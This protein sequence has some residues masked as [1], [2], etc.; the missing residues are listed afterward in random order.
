MLFR[1]LQTREQHIRREKATSNICTAQALLANMAG[2]YAVFHGPAG[3]TKT[4]RRVHATAA[5]LERELGKLGV[6]Q[7]NPV[8]FDTIRLAVPDA[9][10][11][12]AAALSVRQNF[13]YRD[14]GTVNI[15]VDET[16]NLNDVEAIV[17]T[18]AQAL[19]KSAHIDRGEAGLKVDYAA[20]LARTS[21]F[22]THPVFN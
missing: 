17:M 1:S 9:A 19:G 5:L 18:F 7:L 16:T 20:P 4:A 8:Y 13:R 14:D 11:L 12:R 3:L 22:L 2:F 15:A 21:P 6:A 10:A